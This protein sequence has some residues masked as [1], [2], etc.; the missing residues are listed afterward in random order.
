MKNMEK[1]FFSNNKMAIVMKDIIIYLILF[2]F[3]QL[4]NEI[5]SGKYLRMIFKII[6]LFWIL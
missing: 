1:G 2:I 5:I 3:V 6:D 4:K